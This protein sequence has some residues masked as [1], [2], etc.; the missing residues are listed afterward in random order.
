MADKNREDLK[1]QTMCLDLPYFP[2]AKQHF[3]IFIV[4][5]WIL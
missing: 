5:P 3:L 4:A 1:N 2:A